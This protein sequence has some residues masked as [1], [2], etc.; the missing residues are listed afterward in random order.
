MTGADDSRAE[1]YPQARAEEWVERA[2]SEPRGVIPPQLKTEPGHPPAPGGLGVTE[3]GAEHRSLGRI[4]EVL[5][6]SLDLSVLEARYSANEGVAYH[7][8]RVADRLHQDTGLKRA[9]CV[10]NIM[11]WSKRVKV[12]F[13]EWGDLTERSPVTLLRIYQRGKKV[14]QF[15]HDVAV[16]K[17]W[18]GRL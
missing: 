8:N 15:W 2:Y 7:I 18:E 4:R 3:R 9:D 14:L 17:A 10:N 11:F 12:D 1:I 16:R 13:K 5:G 6:N